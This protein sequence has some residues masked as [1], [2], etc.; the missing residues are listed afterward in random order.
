MASVLRQRDFGLLWGAQT[1]SELGSAVTLVAFPLV[2]IGVLHASNFEVGVITASST[3]AW[4]LFGLPAGVWV[5]RWPRR[6]VMI[7][8]DLG[9][10][11]LMA[12]VPLAW[13]F[14]V[15][16]VAQLIG[17]ALLAGVL[18]VFF[19][20]ANTAFLPAVVEPDRLPDGN[21]ALQASFAAAG[22]A[23]PSLGGA[24]VQ[25]FSAPVAVLADAVSF[26]ASAL[27]VLRIRSAE[28]HLAA[29][30]AQAEPAARRRLSA[31]VAEG[32]R[33]VLGNPLTRVIVSGITLSNFLFGGFEAV[34]FVFLARQ[35]GLRASVVGLLFA[36]GGIGALVGSVAA[37]AIARR[38][39]D[40][41]PL[42]LS[43]VVSAAAGL[44]LPLTTSGWGLAWFVTG[45]LAMNAA[46][47]A[48]NVYVLSAVQGGT[49]ARLL[50]RVIAST[51]LFTRG[52][53]ALGG[54]A[55][56]ALASV[57]SPRAALAIL[58]ALTVLTPL[59]LRLSP[60]GRVRRLAELAG[61]HGQSSRTDRSSV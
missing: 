41:R 29:A 30:P 7:V 21:S 59:Q 53:I 35:L 61:P 10:A 25:L 55:G 46:F 19:N 24:L 14:G 50:G 39:G 33:N 49:E 26:V 51:R 37:G 42:W 57:V 38:F 40:A 4:L 43:T 6:P 17:V 45:M 15:L 47:A 20:V 16:S 23:G 44:L 48:F 22:I 8:A 3:A 13:A 34:V 27:C 18:T 5:D 52:A 31:E 11:A 12:S 32:V 58:M 56:G 36:V 2:A 1:V 60:V 54:L 28:P 9:R